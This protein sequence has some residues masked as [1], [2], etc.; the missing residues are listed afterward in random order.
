M[1]PTNNT[2]SR[3]KLLLNR[4]TLR[5][6]NQHESIEVVGGALLLGIRYSAACATMFCTQNYTYQTCLTDTK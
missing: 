1:N 2:P 4:E 5:E 3:R 6:L